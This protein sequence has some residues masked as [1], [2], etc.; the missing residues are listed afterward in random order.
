MVR[1]SPT[2]E[3]PKGGSIILVGS[4]TVTTCSKGQFLSDYS[5][6]KGAVVTLARELGV[7]LAEKNI[8]VNSISPG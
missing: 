6:T 3:N 8:R 4:T 7:E 2:A 1:Q 5:A